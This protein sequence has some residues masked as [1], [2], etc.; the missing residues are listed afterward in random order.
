MVK[1]L[2]L[3]FSFLLVFQPVMAQSNQVTDSI[4]STTIIEY[5]INGNEL[6]FTPLAPQLNQISGAPKAF[7]T[8][9]WE[10]GDGNY[11]TEEKPKH[12]YRNKGVYDIKLWATNNYDTGKPPTTRPKKITIDTLT[13]TY[14]KV[15]SMSENFTLKRNREPV[16]DEEIVVRMSYKNNKAGTTSGKLYMFYNEYKYK[17]NN[18][19]LTDTRTY[20]NEKS[21]TDNS[22]AYTYNIN[23]NQYLLASANS[24]T[25]PLS[26][27]FP[28]STEKTNLPSTIADSKSYYKNFEM[29]EFGNMKPNE[30]RTIF[31]SLK[32]TPEMLKDT[33]AI[34]T[35]RGVYV[36][37]DNFDNHKIKDMEMEI[38]TS[39][40]PNKMS[41]NGTSLNFRAVRS[42]NVIYKIRFQN[43]GEGPAQTIRLEA[44]IPEIFDK[45][46]LQIIDMYPKCEICPEQEVTYSC[47][48]TAFTNSQ[49]IFT[50]K[51]IYLPGSN[52]KNVADRDSTKGFVK[53]SIKF[54]E[55]FKKVKT[56]SKTAIIFDKNEP[57]IT[58][59][60]ATHFNPGISI[61]AKMG[62]NQFSSLKNSKSYFLGATISPYKSHKWYWQA[63]LLNSFH[64]YSAETL[65]EEEIRGNAIGI[66]ALHRT[67]TNTSF[68]NIDWEIPLLAR[69]NINNYIGLGAGVQSTFSVSEKKE[70]NILVEEFEN[71]TDFF[72]MNS[73]V[74]TAEDKSSFTNFRAGLLFEISTKFARVGPSV[75]ARYIVDFKE[76][77]SHWQFYAIWSF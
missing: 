48:D 63:E 66:D 34:I 68:T 77:F 45:T 59:Y 22:I 14:K 72:L 25:I 65:V 40:D 55:D 13:T 42:K 39:H 57:I 67:T 17:A 12:V 2:I 50:F 27:F 28:D 11:S 16:P 19:D 3:V 1:N 15:A 49:V 52:Q 41:S 6:F 44:D 58:N 43:N 74:T 76:N 29:L 7:Y 9:Y 54:S 53:Y 47:L 5:T 69:Y 21:I 62:I 10:F 56:K 36:P 51:N 61:G 23:N 18:F 70:Q 4:S 20:H 24:E 75:S 38:V 73:I 32:T 31:F 8:Y 64:S 46:T 35:I 71:T 30:E 26:I 60:S 33:S 37:D